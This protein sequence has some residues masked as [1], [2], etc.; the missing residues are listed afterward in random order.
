MS[1]YF[2][3]LAGPGSCAFLSC[4]L[5]YVCSVPHFRR[6]ILTEQPKLSGSLWK[7]ISEEAKDFVKKL[8]VK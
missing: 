7:D 8:L 3:V 1:Q 6:S 4:A 5:L 2:C